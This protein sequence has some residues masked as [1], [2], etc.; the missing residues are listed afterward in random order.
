MTSALPLYPVPW[1][2]SVA[3]IDP[4]DPAALLFGKAPCIPWCE[5]TNP[6]VDPEPLLRGAGPINYMA[7]KKG[8]LLF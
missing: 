8:P 6:Y 7:I 1:T 2:D 5:N 4:I 3:F